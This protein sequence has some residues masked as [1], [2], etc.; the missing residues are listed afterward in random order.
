LFWYNPILFAALI[1]WPAFFRRHRAEA[2]LIAAVVLSNV[3]FY[4]PWYL[5]WA[6]HAWGPRFLVTMLPFAILPL[7][8]A[9]EAARRRRWLA[10]GL[11]GLVLASVAVQIL[12][13]VVDFNLY[14][15]DIHAKL[16]LYHPAT[17]FNLAYSPIVRQIAYV[18]PENLDLAWARGGTLN[19]PALL[20]G[21]FLVLVSGLTLWAAL[22]NRPAF[23]ARWGLLFLL[24]LGSVF[25]LLNY[26]PSGDVAEAAVLL[27]RVERSDEA[28]ALTELLLTEAWQDAYDGK[29]WVW[30]VPSKEQVDAGQKATWVIGAGDPEPAA[31]RFQVGSVQLDYYPSSTESFDVA[32]LP[33]ASLE[34]KAYLGYTVELVAVQLGETAVRPGGT[35]PVALTWRAVTPTDNSY[36]TFVHVIDERGEKAGQVDRPPCHGGCPTNTW[37]SGDLVVERYDL[38]IRADT[39]AGRYQIIAGMYDLE[40]GENL[41]W[42]DAQGYDLGPD[43]VLGTVEIQP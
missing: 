22:R 11:V 21:V 24:L 34:K 32:R 37:H 9:M 13:V 31:A 7:A 4:A 14:L 39:P 3:A 41:I 42:R 27:A 33:T 20:K 1:A 28:A 19:W 2:P 8:A 35:L 26:A 30:G 40:T 6:G 17:L 16:G 25:L 12:G 38:P 10:V 23:W 15:E 43:F 29:L 5:W 18:T 36:T